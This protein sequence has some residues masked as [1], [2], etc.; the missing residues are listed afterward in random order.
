[1]AL[2]KGSAPSLLLPW[3]AVVGRA[4]VQKP[5]NM[6]SMDDPINSKLC[7]PQPEGADLAKGPCGCPQGEVAFQ[8]TW[9]PA[10]PPKWGGGCFTPLQ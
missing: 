8:E 4:K 10:G 2:G 3:A 6:G 1:L 5:A 9:C 7:C